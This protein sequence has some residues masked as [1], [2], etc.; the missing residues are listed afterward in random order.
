MDSKRLEFAAWVLFGGL[1]I[2][3]IMQAAYFGSSD[4]ISVMNSLMAFR[5]YNL[6]GLIPIPLLNISF[7]TTGLGALA[8]WDFAFFNYYNLDIF[9][10]LLYVITI[11]LVWGF[12][13]TFA[14]I[15]FWRQN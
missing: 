15:M 8:S 11:G 3:Q 10:Y 13:A 14:G 1:L 5:T 2:S 6:F 4:D 7:F 12:A 9:K